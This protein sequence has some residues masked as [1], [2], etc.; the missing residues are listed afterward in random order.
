MPKRRTK[1]AKRTER[2]KK[3]LSK[4][5]LN[6]NYYQTMK[7]IKNK[8]LLQFSNNFNP[9]EYSELDDSY[10]K[11][12]EESDLKTDYSLKLEEDLIYGCE[13]D[14]YPILSSNQAKHWIYCDKCYMLRLA[15]VT[16]SQWISHLNCSHVLI[17]PNSS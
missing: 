1:S 2:A 13:M 15:N 17:C 3:T 16:Y 6:S 12:K 5:I 11:Q 8:S 7:S 10:I 14:Y 4:V 9:R